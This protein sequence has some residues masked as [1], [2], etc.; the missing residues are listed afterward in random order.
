LTC[1]TLLADGT[2]AAGGTAN[3]KGWLVRIRADKATEIPI[4]DLDDVSGLA[5]RPDGGFA[6]TGIFDSSP[7][8]L[9]RARIMAWSSDE[10]AGWHTDLPSRGRGELTALV[11]LPDGGLA[12]AGHT[13]ADTEEKARLWVVRLD[14]GGAV[15]WQRALGPADVEQRGRAIA[16]STDGSIALA[17]DLVNGN[18]HRADIRRVG[19]CR[20]DAAGQGQNRGLGHR[21]RCRRP[22]AMGA[23]V[24]RG[25]LIAGP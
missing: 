7:S 3:R 17:G 21:P 13:V 20:F 5:A 4:P 12:A 6:A 1:L 19:A 23:E 18:A 16:V 8:E 25:S 22:P 11:A 15:P 10:A 9:G 14:A 2:T 24:S